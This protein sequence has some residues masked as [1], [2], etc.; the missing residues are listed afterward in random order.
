MPAA[1]KKPANCAQFDDICKAA[2]KEKGPLVIRS[3]ASRSDLD[4][5]FGACQTCKG[6]TALDCPD[7]YKDLNITFVFAHMGEWD[8]LEKQKLGATNW[9]TPDELHAGEAVTKIHKGKIE[10]F[11]RKGDLSASEIMAA[12]M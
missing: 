12:C 4:P 11:S 5:L 3:G 8:E 9:F 7:G 6:M 1:L 10:T 2:K